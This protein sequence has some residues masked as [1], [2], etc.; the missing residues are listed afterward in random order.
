MTDP[1]LQ[2]RSRRLVEWVVGPLAR[3]GVDP[4]VL[5]IAG[6]AMSIAT[7]TVIA[8]GWTLPGGLLVL[9]TGGFDMLDGALARVRG[10]RSQFGAFL[11]STLDRWAE[12]IIFAGLIW[13]VVSHG[14]RTEAVLAALTLVGSMLVSYTRARAEG[15]GVECKVGIFQRPERLAVLGISLLGPGWLLTGALWFLAVVTQLTAAHRV[16]HVHREIERSK[17]GQRG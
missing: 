6:L 4:N 8:V 9:V 2:A 11:D 10:V 14:A 3:T 5:T 15:L 7:A 12:G 16:L 13:Y 17:A 1:R